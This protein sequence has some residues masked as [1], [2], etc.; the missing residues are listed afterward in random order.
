MKQGS[1]FQSH[2]WGRHEK[3][4]VFDGVCNFCN[5]FVNFVLERDS[6]GLFK[7]GTLQSQPA[8]DILTQLHL[9]TQ[10]YETFLLLEHGR[11]FTKSTA[12]LKIFRNLSGAWPCLYAFSI[13]PRPLRDMVYSFI[14]RHRYQWMGK[15]D[16]CRVP[17]QNE[18]ARFI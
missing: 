1:S 3:V 16:T 11:V 18:R 5:A 2:D 10:D 6:R 14:A 8:Q 13:V 9:S 12:A 4:I 17:T 15:S 7:F